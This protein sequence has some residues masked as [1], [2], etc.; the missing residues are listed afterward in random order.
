MERVSC[1]IIKDLLPLYVEGI[2]SEETAQTVK[3]HLEICECCQKDYEILKQ[4]L[5]FPSAPKVQAENEKVLKDLKHK[6]KIKRIVTATIAAFVTAIIVISACAVYIH[7]GVVQDRFA[8]NTTITLQDI[9][10]D[11]EWERLEFG[12]SDYL[13]FDH[14]FCE[15]KMTVDANS[16]SAVTI[17][18]SDTDGNIVVDALTVQ[19]GT[20]VS[21]KELERKTDYKVEIQA[22]A[23]FVLIRFY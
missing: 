15:K 18:I 7:V 6:L 16:D 8:Q 20:S 14:L 21:L 9:Q 1:N 22:D 5:V 17:R 23:D 13:N 12:E 2:L 10:T 11:G 19:P 3:S 4:E